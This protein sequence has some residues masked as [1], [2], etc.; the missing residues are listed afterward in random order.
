[1]VQMTPIMG[2]AMRFMISEPRAGGHR[3]EQADAHGGECP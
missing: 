1:M 2:A 3:M